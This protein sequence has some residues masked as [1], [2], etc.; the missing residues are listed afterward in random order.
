MMMHT[1]ADM[2]MFS[3]LVEKSGPLYSQ[4]NSY[5][6][7]LPLYMLALVHI[8]AHPVH[9]QRLSKVYAAKLHAPVAYFLRFVGVGRGQYGFSQPA[10][11]LA[12]LYLQIGDQ[13]LIQHRA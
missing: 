4:T 7:I 11:F 10:A 13:H 8:P 6:R 1:S 2:S 12:S 5:V 3:I 9:Q